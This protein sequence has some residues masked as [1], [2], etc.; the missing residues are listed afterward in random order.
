MSKGIEL[1]PEYGV[2]PCI[3]VCFFCNRPKNEIALLGRIRKRNADGKAVRGSDIEAPK[4]M[5][6]DYEPCEDCQNQMNAGFTLIVATDTPFDRRP[7]ITN[8][9]GKDLYPTG[10]YVTV[11]PEAASK[12]FNL[13]AEETAPGKVAFTDTAVFN[14]IMDGV[15]ED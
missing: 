10:Q 6:L 7:P 3:P 9:D 2:N 8:R 14:W 5:I 4:H 1:S 12:M 15:A 13:P 11:K